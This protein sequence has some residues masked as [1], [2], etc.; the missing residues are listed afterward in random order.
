MPL[1]KGLFSIGF[2]CDDED[3]LLKRILEI[4]TKENVSICWVMDE[5][6]EWQ[7]LDLFN[8]GL[9]DKYVY[10][11]SEEFVFDCVEY[12]RDLAVDELSKRNI[13]YSDDKMAFVQK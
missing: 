1:E 6:R 9:E 4:T 12:E 10:E 7:A 8:R 2:I 5:D 3:E 11:D 13:E